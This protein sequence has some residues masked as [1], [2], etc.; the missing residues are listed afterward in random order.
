MLAQ[1]FDPIIGGEERV[2]EQL[3]VELAKR[4]HDVSVATLRLPGTSPVEDIAGVRV[5]RLDAAVNRVDRLFAEPE[6]RHL[7]PLPDPILVRGLKR[8]VER[9]RPDVVHAHNWIVHSYVPLKARS[10]MPLVLSLHDYSLVCANKRLIR[11]GSV[12]GGPGPLRCLRCAADYYGVAKGV[13]VAGTLM[14]VSPLLRRR[15][16]MFVPVSTAVAEAVGLV[17]GS[18]PY[19]VIPNPVSAPAGG[20]GVGQELAGRLPQEEFILF[21]GDGRTDKGARVLLDA[22]SMLEAPP[23]L[24]FAGREGDLTGL[25]LPAG[26]IVAGPLPHRAALEAVRRS[27]LLVLPSLVPETFGMAVLEAMAAGRAVVA[28]D[29]GGLREL[30]V[31]GETGK[32]VE[33]GNVVALRDAIAELLGDP[34]ARTAMGRRGRLRSAAYSPQEVVPRFERMYEAL[35]EGVRGQ[36]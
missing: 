19:E 31:D 14:A 17:G 4:G 13:F 2:V 5:H 30:V 34:E 36:S 3:S 16:D 9:E 26:V 25:D 27:M 28:S 10:R 21:L 6:R 32:L 33:P 11:L 20:G 29:I 35:R 18:L 7:P 24:V 12:C 1:F 15:V 8:V 22:Y 23:P